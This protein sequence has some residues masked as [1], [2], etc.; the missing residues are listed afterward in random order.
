MGSDRSTKFANALTKNA[1]AKSQGKCAS[2]VRLALEAA[3]ADTKGHPIASSDWGSTLLKIG[4]KEIQNQFD[5]PIKGDI[6]IITKTTKHIYGHIAGYT[7]AEWI[8]D[9]KQRSQAI[10]SDTVSYRYF[11]LK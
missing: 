3:G 4:Y 1:H 11:R 5:Q 6:Y 8:S 9:F 7:G 10:Y 2:Y